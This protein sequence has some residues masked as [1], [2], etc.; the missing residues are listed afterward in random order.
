MVDANPESGMRAHITLTTSWFRRYLHDDL[1]W[2]GRMSGLAGSRGVGKSTLFLQY[3]RDHI[4][5]ERILYVSADNVYFS[6][7]TLVE[8]ADA[9][10]KDGGQ[11]LMIDELHKYADWSRELKRIYDTH[12]DLEIDFT[13]SREPRQRTSAM[14]A[15]LLLQSDAGPQPGHFFQDSGFRD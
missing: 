8:L 10:S 5:E 15:N 4:Q 11:R 2:D 1:A 9:F 3:A 12:P 7:H 6:S 13:G 14:S